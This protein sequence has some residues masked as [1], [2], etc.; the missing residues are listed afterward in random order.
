MTKWKRWLAAFIWLCAGFQRSQCRREVAI[1]VTSVLFWLACLWIT[2]TITIQR[3][4]DRWKRLHDQ[5]KEETR[6]FHLAMCWLSAI[7]M[8]LRSG[9][10]RYICIVLVGVSL[11]NGYHRHSTAL[12]SLK[13]IAWPNERGES[14]LS[15]GHVLAFSDLN[16]IE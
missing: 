13:A 15:F 8:P 11:D 4:Y 9:D 2:D 14:R 16:A 6:S 7:S 10:I 1:C 3:H 12:W 5:M